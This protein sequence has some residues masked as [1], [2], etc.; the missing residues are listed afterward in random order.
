MVKHVVERIEHR[1]CMHCGRHATR[2][3]GNC[4]L[5]VYYCSKACGYVDSDLHSEEHAHRN[6][7]LIAQRLQQASEYTPLIQIKRSSQAMLDLSR[8]HRRAEPSQAPKRRK[9]KPA[10]E[11]NP[12]AWERSHAPVA[13]DP[14]EDVE[15][16]PPPLRFDDG[17][18]MEESYAWDAIKKTEDLLNRLKTVIRGTGQYSDRDWQQVEA[19]LAII[20]KSSASEVKARAAYKP[21]SDKH[22]NRQIK[23]ANELRAILSLGEEFEEPPETEAEFSSSVASQM[24]RLVR[25]MHE[26]EEDA[27]P[28][29]HERRRVH[30]EETVRLVREEMSKQSTPVDTRI[31][32]PEGFED[33]LDVLL[34]EGL[35]PQDVEGY[36]HFR[37]PEALRDILGLLGDRASREVDPD[38]ASIEQKPAFIVEGVG[39]GS[40]KTV[41][42]SESEILTNYNKLLE[43]L[44]SPIP[45]DTNEAVFQRYSE[46]EELRRRIPIGN[47]DLREAQNVN[48]LDRPIWKFSSRRHVVAGK[49]VWDTD[50]SIDIQR[51]PSNAREDIKQGVLRFKNGIFAAAD[52]ADRERFDRVLRETTDKAMKN[53]DEEEGT[54]A[55]KLA[56]GLALLGAAGL[57]I[58]ACTG[59][60]TPD[61]AIPHI[62]AS[63]VPQSHASPDV[64]VANIRAGATVGPPP[65]AAVP[66]RPDQSPL[67][68]DQ[69]SI[70]S[71]FAQPKTRPSDPAPLVIQP[72]SPNPNPLVPA[73]LTRPSQAEPVRPT[74]PGGLRRFSQQERPPPAP[75]R[76]NP[77]DAIIDGKAQAHAIEA[78]MFAFRQIKAEQLADQ[79]RYNENLE[80]SVN[81]LKSRQSNGRTMLE[82]YQQT[83]LP[84]PEQRAI[85]AETQ[86]AQPV[87]GSLHNTPPSRLDRAV[88]VGPAELSVS[89]IIAL[90]AEECYRIPLR[91]LI[92]QNYWPKPSDEAA[93]FLARGLNE[94]SLAGVESLSPQLAHLA[95]SNLTPEQVSSALEQTVSAVAAPLNV[96]AMRVANSPLMNPAWVNI[97]AAVRSVVAGR[98]LH[99]YNQKVNDFRV[100]AAEKIGGLSMKQDPFF[101]TASLEA[102]TEP[103]LEA[104]RRYPEFYREYAAH[105]EAGE[106]PAIARAYATMKH[107]APTNSVR[108]YH[109]AAAIEGQQAVEQAADELERQRTGQAPASPGELERRE[110]R[111]AQQGRVVAWFRNNPGKVLAVSL[112]MSSVSVYNQIGALLSVGKIAQ[113]SLLGFESE[114]ITMLGGGFDTALAW[115][116]LF[117]GVVS[118]VSTVREALRFLNNDRRKMLSFL[119][120][121]V[122]LSKD[123]VEMLTERI[124]TLKRDLGNLE[125][126]QPASRKAKV[127]K[128]AN[129]RSVQLQ[130]FVAYL[131]LYGPSRGSLAHVYTALSWYGAFRFSATLTSVWYTS[132]WKISSIV[133]D[134]AWLTGLYSTFW[135]HPFLYSIG[136]SAGWLV[137]D[138]AYA[139]FALLKEKYIPGT[140]IGNLT[141]ATS[142]FV[143][144]PLE[145]A[146]RLL[147]N[148]DPDDLAAYSA[149]MMVWGLYN[150]M[151]DGMESLSPGSSLNNILRDAFRNW[152]KTSMNPKLRES[153]L[154]VYN[155][156]IDWKGPFADAMKKLF[157]ASGIAKPEGFKDA[158][159]DKEIDDSLIGGLKFVKTLPLL[160]EKIDSG[161]SLPGAEQSKLAQLSK[162]AYQ[163]NYKAYAANVKSLVQDPRYHHLGETMA[164]SQLHW[165]NNT[166]VVRDQ[167]AAVADNLSNVTVGGNVTETD[168]EAVNFVLK[169]F[170]FDMIS[171][172]R[173]RPVEPVPAIMPYG[174]RVLNE[175]PAVPAPVPHGARVLDEPPHYH[176]TLGS[177]MIEKRGKKKSATRRR[178]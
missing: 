141:L 75:T 52:A 169:D 112:L 37:S 115:T 48:P 93:D 107:G 119:P 91:D 62:I 122:G 69:S 15:Q 165:R 175:P 114:L 134:G 146:H 73:G 44:R 31:G 79:K 92:Q 20:A 173:D 167:L 151:D 88:E 168:I 160:Q 116:T 10:R 53:A 83:G 36:L 145:V 19:R 70:P 90:S 104:E 98:T 178:K 7:G 49:I 130:L 43:L 46:I 159:N 77:I 4:D 29:I 133:M 132:L 78:K 164:Q 155:S 28:G 144:F 86:A 142:R 45:E 34:D 12:R 127:K 54:M 32:A 72:P 138:Y 96:F 121:D 124:N 106:P 8:A 177:R 126:Q 6:T 105:R 150:M 25:H 17:L 63:Q 123:S 158:Y 128:L 156:Q 135:E 162:T 89:S 30:H 40:F 38:G 21:F 68:P 80:F 136:A 87:I 154:A 58:Y 166:D 153:A 59:S 65:G 139:K 171:G 76:P 42:V 35:V 109:V 172:V 24:Q 56:C 22:R 61:A 5:G 129:V 148:R 113:Y 66:L 13:E 120:Y 100:A 97:P 47:L 161:L 111:N 102:V 174:A 82:Y 60:A 33:R 55:A 57:T 94:A 110:Q 23:A 117:T 176:E 71:P 16:P 84:A 125:S 108:D 152:T 27:S 140:S 3:C 137:S 118:L 163:E 51:L 143:L 50:I 74:H 85:A 147:F 81:F 11:K 9:E 170:G 18:P 2:V 101:P 14:M 39:D 64:P 26:D 149:V 67:R 41:I 131:R 157:K 1:C 99:Y 95:S 103:I